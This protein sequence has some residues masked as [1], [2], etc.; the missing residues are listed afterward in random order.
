MIGLVV[1]SH[2]RALAE[3]AVALAS[4]MVDASA[5]PAIEVA[6]GLDATTFGTDAAAISEAIDAADSPDGVLVLMDLGSALLSA[7]MAL[8]FLDPDLA[9]RTRLSPAPLVEGL[10][11]AVVTA[12]SGASL[13]AVDAEARQGLLG[14]QHQLADEN[15]PGGTDAAAEPEPSGPALV[16]RHTLTNPH[17]LHARP[18]AAVAAALGGL[19][20]TID[21]RNL[22]RQRGPVPGGS[23]VQLAT[24][25]L[26]LGDDLEAR[27]S[28][29]QAEE[30]IRRLRELAEANFGESDAPGAEAPAARRARLDAPVTAPVRRL[31]G[32][33]DTAGYRPADEAGRLADA[34]ARVDAALTALADDPPERVSGVLPEILR[35]QVAILH[36]RSVAKGIQRDIDAGT[37]AVDAV[38]SRFDEQAARFQSLSDPYLRE[39]AQDVRSL[40]RLLLLTLTGR[41]IAAPEST[42]PR[43]LVGRELDAVT[44]AT[45]DPATTPAI[46]T[47]EPGTQGHGALIA[48]ALGIP[49]YAGIA[50]AETFH[51]GDVATLAPDGTLTRG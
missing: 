44:A 47:A 31:P 3:A 46:V 42:T 32:C 7:E 6:A 1:V 4:E 35:A 49:F 15:G 26:R 38:L 23:V 51:D 11:A 45:L 13:D 43:L 18:A 41:P 29:P 24:L 10:V 12:A 22:T 48:G 28:G 14:K 8:E 9:A 30:A 50:A 27:A 2:S 25:D 21:L 5:R 20:A 37:S 19:D 17:G 34:M 36:D 40:A 33:P 39:R 16:F